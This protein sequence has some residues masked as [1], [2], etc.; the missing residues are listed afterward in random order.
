M[1]EEQ[2]KLIDTNVELN[3]VSTVYEVIEITS[4]SV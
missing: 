2:E 3:A 1:T 4:S